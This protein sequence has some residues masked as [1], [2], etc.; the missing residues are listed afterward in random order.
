MIA[1][2]KLLFHTPWFYWFLF[3][4]SELPTGYPLSYHLKQTIVGL[5]PDSHLRVSKFI[6]LIGLWCFQSDRGP[7]E[8]WMQEFV[9]H[10]MIFLVNV[11]GD[12]N[13][14]TSCVEM[15]LDHL[16]KNWTV[17]WTEIKKNTVYNEILNVIMLILIKANC[18]LPTNISSTNIGL[19]DQYS[20]IFLIKCFKS[21]C[22]NI[23]TSKQS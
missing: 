7:R 9:S 2:M 23:V 22:I 21:I 4:S 14:K 5:N 20:I 8:L 15:F 13:I 18:M 16:S 10:K 12:G 11:S 1:V 19:F 6:Y 17:C 3:T